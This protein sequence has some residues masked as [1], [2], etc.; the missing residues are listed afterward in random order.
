MLGMIC[1]LIQTLSALLIAL[2]ALFEV[3]PEYGTEGGRRGDVSGRR[4][5]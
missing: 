2:F 4:G 5:I 1:D 3:Y